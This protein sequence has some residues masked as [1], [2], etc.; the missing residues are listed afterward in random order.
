MKKILPLLVLLSIPLIPLSQEI[1][2]S[3]K[4]WSCM[5]EHCQSWGSTYSTNYLRFDK[6]TII[7]DTSYKKVWISEDENYEQWNFYGAYIREENRRI[8]YRQMFGEEG[9][10]YDFNLEVGDSV[11]VDNPRAVGEIYLFL[12]EIDSIETEYG[13]QERW[14]LVSNE[15]PDNEYWIRGIGSE[16]GILNSSTGIFGGLCGLYTLLC[17]KE[18]DQM[19]YLNPEYESCY[20][21][22]TG[23]MELQKPDNMFFIQANSNRVSLTFNDQDLSNKIIVLSDIEASIIYKTQTKDV[24][25]NIS[26]LN[27]PAGIYIITVYKNGRSNSQKFVKFN[28]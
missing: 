12:A 22:T 10:I 6:D 25:S 23:S 13:Y 3:T 18:N 8:Y 15:Y 9:L 5:E 26:M 20:L 4:M 24:T 21:Y 28:N 14:R 2:D 11:L 19:V 1:V 27:N 7:N 16:T 17:E